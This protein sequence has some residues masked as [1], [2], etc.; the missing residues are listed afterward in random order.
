MTA[1]AQ[2]E[3]DQIEGEEF[4]VTA[5]RTGLG[6]RNSRPANSPID[7]ITV[8]KF[9]TALQD[10]SNSVKTGLSEVATA[11][12]NSTALM[13]AKLEEI[14]DT[15]KSGQKE[16]RDNFRELKQRRSNSPQGRSPNRL[17]K[18]EMECHY[19][20]EKG[21]FKNECDRYRRQ[22]SPVRQNWRGNSPPANGN[23]RSTS[24]SNSGQDSNAT[25]PLNDKRVEQ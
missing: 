18:S 9:V 17:P 8:N 7:N 5:F 23:W 21:H 12:K 3:D 6:E 2:L 22:Q 13:V 11:Q 24:P 20:N 25:R 19:C 4:A 10:M 1:M 15:T 14:N 16:S